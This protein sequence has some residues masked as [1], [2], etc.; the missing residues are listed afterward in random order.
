M[1]PKPTEEEFKRSVS[2]LFEQMTVMSKLDKEMT[3][4]SS[5]FSAIA[6]MNLPPSVKFDMLASVAN[7]HDEFID[8][9]ME[10]KTQ[11][12]AHEKREDAYKE[13]ERE[14]ERAAKRQKMD[15]DEGAAEEAEKAE[16]K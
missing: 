13:G 12:A 6:K 16:A 1:A 7:F 14:K 3:T 2:G 8:C 5:E 10:I 15:P 11:G 9:L 4:F